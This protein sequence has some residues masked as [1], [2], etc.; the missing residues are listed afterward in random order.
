VRTSAPQAEILREVNEL[1]ATAA[2]RFHD[3]ITAADD[4]VGLNHPVI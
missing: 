3:A 2:E 4:S 1:H